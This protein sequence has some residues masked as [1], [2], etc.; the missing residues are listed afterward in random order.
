MTLAL[1]RQL[2]DL[3][4]FNYV[5]CLERESEKKIEAFLSVAQKAEEKK[6]L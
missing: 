3:I 4:Q 5:E 2:A 6:Q 1:Q